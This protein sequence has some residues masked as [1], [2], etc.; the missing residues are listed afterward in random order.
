MIKLIH[1]ITETEMYVDESR[2][3]EYRNM[4]YRSALPQTIEECETRGK[5]ENAPLEKAVKRV[6]RKKKV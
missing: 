5:T 1:K 3:D 2:V 4:G 6:G